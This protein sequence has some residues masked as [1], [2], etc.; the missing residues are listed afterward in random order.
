MTTKKTATSALTFL[1]LTMA[2]GTPLSHALDG[3]DTGSK[4][5]GYCPFHWDCN[6]IPGEPWPGPGDPYDDNE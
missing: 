4:P 3:L 2:A 6:V 1:T 5:V